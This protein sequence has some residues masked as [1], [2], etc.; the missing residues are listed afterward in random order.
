MEEK[1]AAHLRRKVAS[2]GSCPDL[3]AKRAGLTECSKLLE[4]LRESISTK[5]LAVTLA[6]LVKK[7]I[8]DGQI[9]ELDRAL[10]M[11]IKTFNDIEV[12]VFGPCPGDPFLL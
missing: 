7:T 4:K 8:H 10:Q 12:H 2:L 9:A 5:S 1:I 3:S 6:D 11:P